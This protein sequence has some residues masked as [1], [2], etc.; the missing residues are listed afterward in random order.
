MVF[1]QYNLWPHLTVME[2]LIEA[3]VKLLGM[4]K[5]AAME[6]GAICWP[7]YN[8][9]TSATPGRRGCLAVSSSGWPSPVP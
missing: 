8:W 7:S 9:P 4:S 1:Q 2:N 5:A 3:P 6:K